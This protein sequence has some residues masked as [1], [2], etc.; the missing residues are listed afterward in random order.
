MFQLPFEVEVVV[1]HP[2]FFWVLMIIPLVW[3]AVLREARKRKKVLCD[4]WIA[5]HLSSAV[6]PGKYHRFFWWVGA[7]TVLTLLVFILAT[8]ERKYAISQHIYGAMRITFLIDASRSAAWGE[9]V[10]PNRLSAEKKVVAD[11]VDM[12]W[13]DPELKGRYA[14]AIIPFAGAAQPFYSPFTTSRSQILSNLEA[15]NERTVTK[16]GTSI[17]AALRAYDEL[18][19]WRPSS[20]THTVDLGILISDGGKEEGRGT[21]R[22]I[23]NNIVKN[24]RDPYRALVLVEGTRHIIQS[25]EITR[26]VALYTVGV[27]SVEI[28]RM[29][30]RISVSV[31]LVIRDKAGNFLD[32]YRENKAD[33]K[34]PVFES[35][36]DEDIL[37][38]IAA[39][40]GGAYIHFSEKKKLLDEF[41]ALVLR[42]RQ[43]TGSVIETSYYSLRMWL[44]IPAFGI[45]F[46]LFG[47]MEAF[48]RMRR[49]IPLFS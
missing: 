30:N 14:I 29:G 33:P 5:L 40:G 46:V 31:P 23:L 35:K 22:A 10:N 4:P 44:L 41:K 37:E 17:W 48:T 2:E 39:M 42:H 45:C 7:S 49:K 19:L 36:L 27:G 9:D 1:R 34:S 16:G 8:P 12:L 43:I 32:Y 11:F 3:F 6:L 20:G 24:L 25:N 38:D 26:N 21:E 18:L 13:F 47:Y 28:D 15:I